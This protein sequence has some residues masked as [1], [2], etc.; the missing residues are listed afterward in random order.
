MVGAAPWPR[1]AQP[2]S[3]LLVG[4]RGGGRLAQ[5]GRQGAGCRASCD[6][7]CSRVV[8]GPKHAPRE[9]PGDAKGIHLSKA[10]QQ[11]VRIDRQCA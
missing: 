5:E 8:V 6:V 9:T 3:E 4:P 11:A 1:A 2:R 7:T 10:V